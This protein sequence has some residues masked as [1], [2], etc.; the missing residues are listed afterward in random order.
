MDK[1]ST[2]DHAYDCDAAIG[3]D[4]WYCGIARPESE[5]EG[6]TR[7]SLHRQNGDVAEELAVADCI[8]GPAAPDGDAGSETL[9]W[10][11]RQNGRWSL[12]MYS[13]GQKHE[14][15]RTE[16]VLR[17]P[18]VALT[19]VGPYVCCQEMGETPLV[20]RLFDEGGTEI[21]TTTGRQPVITGMRDRLALLVEKPGPN[22]CDLQ[23]T[24]LSNSEVE[25]RV[26][27]PQSWDLHMN[28]SMA[29]DP[30]A[31]R[32]WIVHEA[33]PGWGLTDELC[34]HRD[35][36]LW[37]YDLTTG[38]LRR[39]PATGNGRI[40]LPMVSS[41]NLQKPWIRPQVFVRKG[42]PEVVCRRYR[43]DEDW[44]RPFGWD[45]YLTRMTGNQWGR[46][47]RITPDSGPGDG[48]YRILPA[49]E[50]KLWMFVPCTLDA[51]HAPPEMDLGGRTNAFR[52]DI[53]QCDARTSLGETDLSTEPG[54]YAG[55]YSVRQGVRDAALKPPEL[56]AD[57]P[58]H[59]VWAD[60]HQ[61]SAYS[62]CQAPVDGF[63]EE[64]LRFQRDVLGCRVFTFGEHSNWFGPGLL[65]RF[66]DTIEAE[67]GDD[68]IVI[69]GSEPGGTGHDTN[70]YALSREHYV[71]MLDLFRGL[72]SP[73]H[74]D[75]MQA[76]RQNFAP[77]EIA[78]IRH[79]HGQKQE[80]IDRK[81]EGNNH[82]GPWGIDNPR[83]PETF[84]PR[85]EP[86]MEA[87]QVR[88]NVMLES[89]KNVMGGE[90]HLPRFPSNFLNAGHQLGL[91]GGS[92]HN[93]G[94]GRNHFA[95]TGFWVDEIT[96][97]A[98]WDALWERRTVAC[99]NGKIAVWTT[100]GDAAIG[101]KTTV[102]GDVSLQ[103]HATCAS[104]LERAYLIKDG[105]PQ[106]AVDLSGKRAH[107]EVKDAN[108]SAG[109]HWYCVTVEGKCPFDRYRPIVAHASPLFIER[110]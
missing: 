5:K 17:Q 66:M 106:N 99:S 13:A 39:G 108:P 31:Q 83:C 52:V 3:S 94:A 73:H 107:V 85:V 68:G 33:A 109:P 45:V 11:E 110:R 18:N 7:L 1:L 100:C 61:H 84:E 74:R 51:R 14:L 89:G 28:A 2:I 44:P 4:G 98:V 55:T 25:R 21:H 71:R 43:F 48:Q 103:V 104:G 60:M 22:T 69:Y 95:L 58:M 79:Y 29:Y 40:P 26:D 20:V 37:Q 16:S 23:L 75:K 35:I 8:R 88:G 64:N 67:A 102:T 76:I 38:E 53:L 46:P 72:D 97:E 59:L 101:E 12:V 78:V 30:E 41:F 9:A 15:K 92:D 81:F 19:D 86:A 77:R 57:A 27:L 62:R 65:R 6:G 80:S 93:R 36:C 49:G 82:P 34:S 91:V 47:A 10:T 32:L 87:M 90:A 24:V 42:Q 63:P 50:E 54:H 70:Y 96:A 105:R 56:E